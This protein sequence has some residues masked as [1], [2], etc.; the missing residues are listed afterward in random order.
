MLKVLPQLRP[1][2]IQLFNYT[3][4]INLRRTFFYVLKEAESLI[5]LNKAASV[6]RY[7]PHFDGV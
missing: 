1:L 4:S 7:A 5:S 2:Q 6:T 3:P